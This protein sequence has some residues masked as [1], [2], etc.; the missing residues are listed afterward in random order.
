MRSR[1]TTCRRTPARRSPP[2]CSTARAS[3][4]GI[5]PRTAA[6]R[7]RRCSSGCSPERAR[8]RRSATS[9]C[10]GSIRSPSA[11]PASRAP[12]GGYVVFVDGGFPGDL[13]RA[14]V[15]DRKRSYAQAR[16]T[17]LLEPG[18][19]RVRAA[20]RRIPARRGRC[21]AT[22]ASSRS[23]S[24]Q[25]DEALRRIGQLDGFTL[26]PIVAGASQ[27]WR[28]RNKLEYSFGAGADGTLLCGFHAPGSWERIEP[29]EDCL[30]A[31]ERGQRGR[32]ARCSRSAA[33]R[34]SRPFDRRTRERLPAQPRRPR[35][36]PHRPAPGAPRDQPRASSTRD[37]ARRRRALPRAAVDAHR[38]AVGDDGRRPHRADRR[39]RDARRADRRARA[40]RSRPRR[41][42][43]PTPR[44]PSGSTRS[45]SRRRRC[46]GWE[47]V[48]DLYC[49]IGS[50]GLSL[51]R[52]RRHGPRPRG[53]RGGGR[54]RDRQRA[55]QRDHQRRRSTPATC[56]SRCGELVAR[57]GRPD[58]VVVDP[59][60]A[61]LSQKI[62]RR[63]DRGGAAADRLRLVQPDDA[64]PERGAA[65][66]GRA[67][68]WSASRPSTC[69]RRPRISS[70]WRC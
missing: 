17:E 7:R 63:L 12:P 5:R 27:Q 59:P 48:Y 3:G 43:R 45:S 68:G 24:D 47:R 51:A 70:A 60:R 57:A 44:W 52:A 33:T 11:A 31:S 10:C 39:R 61:G 16:A 67:G 36:A 49:G 28:Y 20:R 21:C 62:V 54:R 37:G 9:S 56:G 30:L 25:V 42:S 1:C 38:R 6:T 19:D 34:A 64:R 26:E 50:I 15:H 4:S 23:S 41:S 32:A 65:R 55:A 13:V 22:S 14:R 69:S 40:A 35:G 66:R 53:R 2:R 58:L 46:D 29:L 18:P 8:G